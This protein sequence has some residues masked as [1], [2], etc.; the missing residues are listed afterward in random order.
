REREHPGRPLLPQ[1]QHELELREREPMTRQHPVQSA[2]RV[3]AQHPERRADARI[4][5]LGPSRVHCAWQAEFAGHRAARQCDSRAP[6]ACDTVLLQGGPLRTP[7]I[8]LGVRFS[9]LQASE[10]AFG[11]FALKPGWSYSST[12]APEC[13]EAVPKPPNSRSKISLVFH[14]LG[15]P[16]APR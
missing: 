7:R 9:R 16:Q 15:V 13:V 8:F 2:A 5:D 3:P 12:F 14:L 11:G 1:R 4:R 6:R 10:I